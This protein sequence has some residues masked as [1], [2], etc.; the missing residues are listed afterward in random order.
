MT[1][2]HQPASGTT[3]RDLLTAAT[4]GAC[5]LGMVGLI[6]AP[7]AGHAHSP[8]KGFIG[9]RP[10]PW[11]TPLDDGAVRCELCP[12]QCRLTAGQRGPCRVREHRQ[13]RLHTLAYGNPVLV[14]IDPVERKPFLHVLPASRALSISTAGCN[15]HCAFCEVWDMALVDPEEVHAYDMS[16]E[17]VV[18]QARNAEVAA[19]SYAFGEP[20]VFYEYMAA[21]AALAKQAGLRNLLHSNGFISK[22]PLDAL[23]PYLDAV[24]I[25]LKGFSRSFYRDVCQGELAPVLE[26][27]IRLKHHRIHVEITTI[28][29][30]SLNDDM[31]QMAAMCQWI[32]EHLGPDT[33]LHLARFYPLYRLRNLPPTPVATIERAREIAHA[34]GLRYVYVSR[35]T[36][37]EA[38]NTFCP[39]CRK[40]VIERTGFIVE[41]MHISDGTCDHCGA[42]IA[43][44][45]Q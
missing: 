27:L 17:T 21:T 5:A 37:H 12:R 9:S 16:P 30:P 25:D 38:E 28:L 42:V 1:S 43:G 29:I 41:A 20:V 13:G 19:I 36:G 24:N 45:W 32:H 31:E 18:E 4:C 3:R 39:Q 6:T 8:R 10:S 15:M 11:A 33:P 40:R 22:A 7:R 44:L 2:D 14:Q 35:I 23:A 26:T 34:A